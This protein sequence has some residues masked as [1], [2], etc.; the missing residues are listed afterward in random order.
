MHAYTV[1]RLDRQE[2]ETVA[3]VVTSL[4][5]AFPDFVKVGDEMKPYNLTNEEVAQRKAILACSKHG[6]DLTWD[7]VMLA[8]EGL[9]KQVAQCSIEADVEY[10]MHVLLRP[11]PVGTA[12]PAEA[13]NGTAALVTD[14]LLACQY[15]AENRGAQLRDAQRA[16]DVIREARKYVTKRVPDED[17]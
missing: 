16:L 2:R 6:G 13:A 5:I 8:Y 1:V 3:R 12:T 7:H 14:P 17:D 4:G 11:V 15:L 10:W 9:L